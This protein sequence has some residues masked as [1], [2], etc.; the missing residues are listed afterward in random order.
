MNGL[1][2]NQMVNRAVRLYH[3]GKFLEAYELV[4]VNAG[5]VDGNQAQIYN[6]RFC[7]ACRAGREGLAMS[8]IREAVIDQG[9]WYSYESFLND[10]DLAPLRELHEFKRMA[11]ICKAREAE[12][13][14][15]S[16][17]EVDIAVSPVEG[18]ITLLMALHGN[19]ENERTARSQWIGDDAPGCLMAFPRSSQI[20]FSGAYFWTDVELGVAEVRS[21]LQDLRRYFPVQSVVLA[22]FSAGARVALHLALE[23]E[24]DV[25]GLIL[26]AP[27]LPD[28]DQLAPKIGE[29]RSRDVRCIT[30]WGDQ[31]EDCKEH[32]KALNELFEIEG[33]RH[34][35]IDIPGMEHDVPSD[36]NNLTASMLAFIMEK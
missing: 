5:K 11:E 36:L 13:R 27:W 20:G 30:I 34:R 23:A 33:V 15:A 1:T 14:S 31:D 16:A 19:E 26:I 9:F 28:L 6:F 25:Q 21:H 12:A 7:L 2:Y 8:I 3:Q 17:P 32:A 24:S 18:P 10:S 22:G 29:L 35:K 4:T